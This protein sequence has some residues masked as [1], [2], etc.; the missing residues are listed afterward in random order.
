MSRETRSALRRRILHLREQ[1][2]PEERSSKSAVITGR[3]LALP[4]LAPGCN[5]FCYVHF[6]SE[7]ETLPLIRLCLNHGFRVS[8]PRVVENGHGLLAC[9]IKDPDRDLLP[10]YCGI[11]EPKAGQPLVDPSSIQVAVV[12][13][14][15]FD[16]QG[17]RL[18]YGGGY[19]D[20]FF[21]QAAPQALRIG[22]AFDMQVIEAVPLEPHDQKLHCLITETRT[23]RSGGGAP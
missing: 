7:V 2:A 10:G 13:G 16:I 15:V 22:L 11:P 4:F 17:G 1:L 5:I 20:R 23:I 14:S 19:Y 12:P 9:T 8:V 6:R 3:F 21:A 18:G